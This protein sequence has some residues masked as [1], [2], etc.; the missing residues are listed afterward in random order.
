MGRRSRMCCSCCDDSG[1]H[2]ASGAI[3]KNTKNTKATE[4]QP[5]FSNKTFASFVVFVLSV[6]APEAP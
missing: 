4:V 6:N 5:W 1:D 3:T 2:G